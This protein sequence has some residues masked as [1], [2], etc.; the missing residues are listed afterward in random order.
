MLEYRVL[1]ALSVVDEGQDV[2]VGGARQR[3][4][5]AMLLLNRNRVV[6]ADRLA[7]V[8]F[9]GAPSS[10]AAATLRSYIAR[11]RRVVEQVG[12]DT[13][14]LTQ[15]PGYKLEAVDEA[16][17]AACFEQALRVGQWSLARGDAEAASQAFRDGLALW[18][19]DAYV[20]FADEDWARGEAQRL[21]ELRVV[22]YEGLADT[23]LSANRAAEAASLLEGLLVDDPLRESFQARLMVALYRSGRQV[24]ALRSYRGNREALAELGLSPSPEL[25]ELE[26]RIL[27]HDE[28]LH[29]DQ[30]GG[31]SLRGYR[32]GERL[33]SG[34]DGTVYAA[35]L[36]GVVRDVAIRVVPEELANRSDFVRTFEADARTVASLHH[37]AVVPVHDWWREPG[38][39][40]VVMRRMRGGTLRDRLRRGPLALA[41]AAEVVRRVGAA[42]VAAAKAGVVHGRVTS[43][44]VFFDELGEAY[45]GDFPLGTSAT[46]DGTNGGRGRAAANELLTDLVALASEAIAGRRPGS[47]A[48]QGLSAGLAGMWSEDRT[49]AGS[50]SPASLAAGVERM[51]AALAGETVDKRA[52]PPNPYKGLRAFDEPDAEDFFGRGKLVDQMLEHL[53]VE[54]VEDGVRLLLVVGGSGSGKSSAVRAGLVPRLRRGGVPGSAS[55][56]VVAM[57]PGK[58]PLG[59]LAEALRQVAVV[60]VERLSRELATERGLHEAVQ[61]V[62]P[63]G[64]ELLLLVD[65]LEELF[66][67]ASEEER[68]AFLGG[69][70]HATSVPDSHLR[71]VATLR[72]DF[73]DRPL[74]FPRFAAAVGATVPV[75]ALS[76]AELEAAIVGP[77]ERVG[78]EVEPAL[79]AELVGAVVHE[80]AA[81]PS[82][83]F[84]L[85]ELSE[86]SAD[87]SLTL[88]PYRELGGL[89]GAIAERA[90]QLYGTLGPD[91]QQGVRRMFEQLVVVGPNGEPTRRRALSTELSLAFGDGWVDG[92]DGVVEAWVNARLLTLD[93]HPDTRAPTVEVAHEALLTQWPRLRRWVDEDREELIVLGQLREASAAWESLGRDPGAFYRGIR[94]ESALAVVDSREF[95]LPPA[96]RA[97]L[98]ASRA[99]RD[100]ERRSEAERVRQVARTNRRLRTLL[101]AVGVALAVALVVGTVAVGQRNRAEEQ[102]RLAETRE[103]AAASAANLDVDPELSMLLALEAAERSSDGGGEVLPEAEEALHRAVTVS[104]LER[105]LPG[106]G[107]WDW[108][109]DGATFAAVRPGDDDPNVLDIRDARTGD[110][111]RTLDGHQAAVTG[112][113]YSADGSLVA[114]TGGDGTLRVWQAGTGDAIHAVAGGDENHVSGPAFSTD[115]TLVAASWFGDGVTRVVEVSTGRVVQ[116]VRSVP[117]PV[118]ASFSPDSNRIAVAS[119][120]TPIAKIIDL[121]TGRELSTLEGHIHELA[122]VA[123]SPDGRSIATAGA[124]GS[125]R[126]WDARTGSQRFA[127]LGHE[128]YVNAVDWSPESS[129]LATGSDDGTAKVWLLTEGGP[130]QLFTLAARDMENGVI[131]V[132]FSPDGSQLMTGDV[133]VAA[134]RVWDVS[135]AGAA[136]VANFPAVAFHYG[137]IAF[138]PDGRHVVA[139]SVG[140]SVTIWDWQTGEAV[141]T[142]GEG[143]T[144]DPA[145]VLEPTPPTDLEVGMIAVAPQGRSLAAVSFADGGLF[146]TG[147]GTD[148]VRVWDRETARKTLTL[149][150]DGEIVGLALAPDGERLAVALAEPGRA[151]RIAIFDRAGDQIAEFHAKPPVGFGQLA[152]TPDGQRVIAP[153]APIDASD[154]TTRGVDLW[155]WQRGEVVET[156]NTPAGYGIVS[157]TGT[158]IAVQVSAPGTGRNDAELW[159]IPAG[160]RLARLPGGGG[161]IGFSADGRTVVTGGGDGVARIWDIAEGAERI[162]LRGHIGAISDIAV[163]PDGSQAATIGADGLVRVWALRLDDLVNLA[164]DSLTRGLTDAEC[165]RYL[166]VD[167]C[168]TQ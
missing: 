11:L 139:P 57:T 133:D 56:F 114:T 50:V 29:D 60:D 151:D 165:R 30:A 86:H 146:R 87:G 63:S 93:R 48:D 84:T 117:A 145:G 109:P 9:A 74:R 18:R 3:R 55:W 132:V 75:A 73:Y 80:P 7:D 118:A 140:N 127:L 70:A 12:S 83:Q 65:Q 103:L 53:A 28:S 129:H 122:D 96:E 150:P 138:T 66:T 131:G 67:L 152:F 22:A 1:G 147:F 38:A 52:R 136:E 2:S 154:T 105:R 69:I 123:W 62:V 46:P 41:D 47:G 64:G 77:A 82:L 125:A 168:D 43:D 81:L 5:V 51:V 98:D 149:E 126:V 166:H 106:A 161:S 167:R 107:V 88:S 110:V 61:R 25:G 111:V 13:R 20:E 100:R 91:A 159:D 143:P 99:E 124:D 92:I 54:E 15:P 32:L 156:I 135:I 116:E 155:D 26:R 42:L 121:D 144:P 78:A 128:A 71:V 59:E 102:G 17:D 45:L 31:S 24:E 130:R 8:V 76:A 19:G 6:P 104:R 4:L 119:G 94:L 49:A 34:R 40:Y 90:E 37:E 164:E 120:L 14:I 101:A 134:T 33:G 162:S 68:R 115:G 157:P 10:R 23:L 97:F 137:A 36:P 85:A 153:R 27:A 21:A 89:E 158:H 160:R 79:V 142:L 112:A 58:S 95:V 163:N 148:V 44:S 35:R 39:A 108:S 141:Q 72:A 113:T 16:F